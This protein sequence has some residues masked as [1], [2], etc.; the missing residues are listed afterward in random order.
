[1]PHGVSRLPGGVFNC[2]RHT[3]QFLQNRGFGWLLEND[4]EDEDEPVTANHL[5][6]PP[7]SFEPLPIF[8]AQ[9]VTITFR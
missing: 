4:E 5:P 9:I 8:S 6:N 7:R 2:R 3:L 1:M